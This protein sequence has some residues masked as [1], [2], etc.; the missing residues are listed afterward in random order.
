MVE[1]RDLALMGATCANG[2]VNPC[3]GDRVISATCTERV[4]S[5]MSTCGMYDAAGQASDNG[6]G[7]VI[8]R[9][10]AAATAHCE[11]LLLERYGDVAAPEDEAFD[12]TDHPLLEQVPDGLVAGLQSHM[13]PR[14]YA[15]GDLIVVE[16]DPDAGVFLIMTGRV[17]S[18]LTTVAGLRRD[19]ATL[20]PGTCF[21]DV[22]VATGNPHPLSMHAD[23]PVEALELTR[24]EFAQIRD[25]DPQLHAAVLQV[26]MY[27]IHDDLDRSLRAL[28]NGRVVPMTAS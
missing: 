3:T 9:S 19:V 14:T 4:L 28:G 21:G 17:R 16:N 20:T 23:G 10:I 25:D 7:Q 15:D 24:A 2:G 27:S 11:D 22:Y 5:V 6:D 12:F 1:C 8:F 13:A 26:F 18:S